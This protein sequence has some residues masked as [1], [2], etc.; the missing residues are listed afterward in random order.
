MNA[1][2]YAYKFVYYR[3]AVLPCPENPK[4]NQLTYQ[5]KGYGQRRWQDS[6]KE[7]FQQAQYY[8]KRVN[9]TTSKGESYVQ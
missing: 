2:I 9:T 6:T 3:R 5:E 4:F 8:G 7:L 1:V